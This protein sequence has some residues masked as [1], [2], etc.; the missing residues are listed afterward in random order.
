M[1]MESKDIT[2]TGLWVCGQPIDFRIDQY[3]PANRVE[4]DYAMYFACPRVTKQFRIGSRHLIEGCLHIQKPWVLIRM[5]WR[6]ALGTIA[7]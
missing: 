7:H 2:S 6:M 3:A 5:L 4:T 1:D